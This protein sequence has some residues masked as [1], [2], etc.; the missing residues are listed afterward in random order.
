MIKSYF[1]VHKEER[2]KSIVEKIV[3]NGHR[4]VIVV[5]KKKVLGSI[6][7]GDILKALLYKKDVNITARKLMNKSFKFLKTKDKDEVKKNFPEPPSFT[8]TCSKF[9]Y[10]FERFNYIRKFSFK[11]EMNILGFIPARKGSKGI[12]GKNFTKLNGHPLI[13]YTLDVLTKLKKKT[14]ISIFYFYK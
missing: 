12:P 14:R 10:D 11:F 13:K 1:L 6:S 7:E 5:D 8:Y 3:L 9:Q 4:T 2:L